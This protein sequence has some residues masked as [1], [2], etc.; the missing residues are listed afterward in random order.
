M[1]SVMMDT[2]A[3][4]RM[5]LDGL[6]DF[7]RRG[8][9]CDTMLRAQ[10]G[11]ILAHSAV[12]AAASAKLKRE[13]IRPES[14][15]GTQHIVELPD[16]L[17][18]D[19]RRL[20]EY[21]YSGSPGK[22]DSDPSGVVALCETLEVPLPLAWVDQDQVALLTENML[23]SETQLVVD[24]VIGVNDTDLS[25][26][27][28]KLCEDGSDNDTADISAKAADGSVAESDLPGEGD[29]DARNYKCD[30]CSRAFKRLAALRL[31]S[32]SHVAKRGRPSKKDKAAKLEKEAALGSEN[33][34]QS[35]EKA[36]DVASTSG[37][38]FV[39]NDEELA[40][41]AGEND[42][43]ST[44]SGS[45]KRE[46]KMTGPFK[47][48]QRVCRDCG[49]E[50]GCSAHLYAHRRRDHTNKDEFLYVCD[51]CEHRFEFPSVLY[52][53]RVTHDFT[54]CE[55]CGIQ[56][57][58][59]R[60]LYRHRFSYHIDRENPT[61]GPMNLC[62]VCGQRFQSRLELRKHRLT[63][64]QC[65]FCGIWFL[66]PSK[67]RRH[68]P[69]C[70]RRTARK[71]AA[72]EAN[73]AKQPDDGS[74]SEGY[75]CGECGKHFDRRTSYISHKKVHVSADYYRGIYASPHHTCHMC[76][77]AFLKPS[78]LAR[79]IPGCEL[80]LT[81]R[82]VKTEP[83]TEDIE[84]SHELSL[85]QPTADEA[86]ALEQQLEVIGEQFTCG[87]CGRIFDKVTSLSSHKKVHAPDE[88]RCATCGKVFTK[89][90][91]LIAHER[92]HTN[93]RPFSCDQ[94][95]VR[96]KQPGQVHR[97]A[98]RRHSGGVR[99]HMC[100]ECGRTFTVKSDLKD[101]E[102]I[103]TGER[104]HMC[105][106]CGRR[107]RT[108]GILRVHERQHTGVMPFSCTYCGRRFAQLSNRLKHEVTHTGQFPL[109]CDQC[110]RGFV[111]TSALHRHELYHSGIRPHACPVCDR[112]FALK[113]TLKAHVLI[114]SKLRQ[115][116]CPIC[117]KTFVLRNGLIRHLKI[118]TRKGIAM[119]EL[120]KVKDEKP[121]M[122]LVYV[123][124]EQDSGDEVS[125]E[126][127]VMHEMYIAENVVEVGMD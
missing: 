125:Y 22:S 108:R 35:L 95:G 28:N 41:I 88:F 119:P 83:G 18:D 4:M 48:R 102:R 72:A 23:K 101:H 117:H 11:E 47:P 38:C 61:G 50:F 126:P 42:S 24:T 3:F 39:Y 78:R 114:H 77:Q 31:H 115:H 87:D 57:S 2:D 21:I 55:P 123:V 89:R 79:H 113:S 52:E 53:H 105:D 98:L 86:A 43:V 75:L 46:R 91:Y 16:F 44:G 76:G 74:P 25:S 27:V 63:H 32:R 124:N 111:D 37:D 45:I 66:K 104:A 122:E 97:H 58:T 56:F 54:V 6:L 51:C 30:V 92:K 7:Q 94:C 99:P 103:H 85:I 68:E 106:Q 80:R 15:P 121:Q 29:C 93:E 36:L 13:L 34:N 116:A 17:A 64:L 12:L 19:V 96:F 67:L 60:D 118:H 8:V 73:A 112:T 20:L 90:Y 84:G 49:E 81:N 69:S 1:A 110:G 33:E 62:R 107:F 100:S 9:L 59:F 127:Q 82:W 26:V 5:L 10:G 14:E 40:Q 70:L 65:Q 71:A 109:H 120:P